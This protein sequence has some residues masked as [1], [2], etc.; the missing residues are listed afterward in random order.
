M[1]NSDNIKS[2][3]LLKCYLF[4]EALSY[5]QIYNSTP[6]TLDHLTLFIFFIAFLSSKYCIIYLSI[7]SLIIFLHYNI[8]SLKVT[9]FLFTAVYPAPR[10]VPGPL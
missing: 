10:I 9:T 3:S 2:K 5:Y 8:N 1:I 4:R 7:C 6:F